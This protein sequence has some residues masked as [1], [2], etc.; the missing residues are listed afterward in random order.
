MFF[1][2]SSA[3]VGRTGVLLSTLI[4]IQQGKQEGCIDF[5]G[6]VNNLRKQRMNIIQTEVNV[7]LSVCVSVSVCL[8][9]CHTHTH[10]H[11][12]TYTQTHIHTDTD[13][14]TDNEYIVK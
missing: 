12:I 7:C 6:I 9:V 13:T 14:H 5:I 8:S 4:G 3:G 2:S 1:L 11:N 10:I